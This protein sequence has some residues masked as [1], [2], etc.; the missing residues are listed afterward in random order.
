MSSAAAPGAFSALV[1]IWSSAIFRPST[2]AHSNRT[3]HDGAEPT[4]NRYA[5]TPATAPPEL[6]LAEIQLRAKRR[7]GELSAALETL[8]G[9]NLKRVPDVGRASKRA[10]LA[11]AG[12]SKTEAHRCEQLARGAWGARYAVTLHVDD[13]L[14]VGR[15]ERD[16]LHGRLH[17]RGRS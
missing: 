4:S 17:G 15:V 7:I 1:S 2:P 6:F 12:L 13:A 3:R 5:V 14:G 9:E 8:E 16:C 11:A 10:A